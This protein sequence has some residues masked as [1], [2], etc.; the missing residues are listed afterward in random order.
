[1]KLLKLMI[2]LFALMSLFSFE[3]EDLGDATGDDELADAIEDAID[4]AWED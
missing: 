1:M 4:D 2:S 3:Y